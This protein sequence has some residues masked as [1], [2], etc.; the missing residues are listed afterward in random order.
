[1]RAWK[2]A[3]PAV[4]SLC[5]FAVYGHTLGFGF[6]FDDHEQ[7]VNNPWVAD[8]GE[9]VQ[10]F[11][12]HS[13]G[14]G[15]GFVPISYRPMVYLTYAVERA[16]FGIEPLG[17]HMVNLAVHSINS[18]IL[19]FLIVRLMPKGAAGESAIN[20][21]LPAFA[22]ALLFAIHPVNAETVSWAGCVPELFYTLLGLSIL[23]L[24]AADEDKRAATGPFILYRIAPGVLF[25]FALLFKETAVVILPLV[26]AHDLIRNG[27]EG[28]FTRKRM[29]RYLPFM[30]AFIAYLV[31]RA[32]VMGPAIAPAYK[33]HGF[34]SGGLF[35]LNSTVLFSR[36][37]ASLVWPTA[38]PMQ[39][40]DPVL[41]PFEPRAVAAFAGIA[42]AL[43]ILILFSRKNRLGFFA[44]AILVLPI[45]P[46]LYS[47]AVS[48]VPFADR[49]LY[50]PAAGLGL[51]A[52]LLLGRALSGHIRLKPAA[53][54]LI[55]V[56]AV[57]Y[58]VYGHQR[59]LFWENDMVLWGS[60]LKAQP[61]NYVAMHSIAKELL[62]GGKLAEATALLERSLEENLSGAHP[63]KSMELITRRALSNAYLKAGEM[64]KAEGN[65]LEYL[66]MAP[67]D[68]SA[69]YNLGLINQR[70]GR[71]VDALEYYEKA[72]LFAVKP[73][74]VEDIRLKSDECREALG[75]PEGE[76]QPPGGGL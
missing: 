15:E 71:C 14:W 21:A 60:A 27:V 4:L 6:V 72:R 47:P 64:D 30:A 9:S 24:A 29:A 10:A 41:S 20:P 74:L 46:A 5:V 13:F 67:E 76:R 19:F 26:F 38:V 70:S 33:L 45:L 53:L 31:I 42:T 34:L 59:S 66:R 75:A 11:Y 35:A 69:N 39:M 58:A 51:F 73:A 22:G 23:F 65:L 25:F 3:V 52:A 32:I 48:R 49:Y 36:Y 62:E 8:L 16:F 7:I 28:L 56:I 55:A 57:P 40:L 63:E 1:M 68:P 2:L 17:W 12:S 61:G 43:I 54:A 37:L 50:F 44:L 18:V